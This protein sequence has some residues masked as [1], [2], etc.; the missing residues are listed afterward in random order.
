M[1]AC[2]FDDWVLDE[3]F[4]SSL[5]FLDEFF[6]YLDDSFKSWKLKKELKKVKEWIKE[7]GLMFG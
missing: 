5:W 3:I 2:V 1:Y 4:M 7:Y 6:M